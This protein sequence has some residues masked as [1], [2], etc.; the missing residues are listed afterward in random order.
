MIHKCSWMGIFNMTYIDS[1][2]HIILKLIL[3]ERLL[4]RIRNRECLC[5]STNIIIIKYIV[6]LADGN[7]YHR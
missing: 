4:V 6:L 2:L 3:W 5:T 1:L 7:L